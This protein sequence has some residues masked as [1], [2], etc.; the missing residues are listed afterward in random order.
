MSTQNPDANRQTNIIKYQQI[1]AAAQ[2]CCSQ[3]RAEPVMN[4]RTDISDNSP[5]CNSLRWEAKEER[6][7]R[8]RPGRRPGAVRRAPT[9]PPRAEPHA[10]CQCH[11]RPPFINDDHAELLRETSKGSFSSVSRAS[12][13]SKLTHFVGF[14]GVYKYCNFCTSLFASF[15]FFSYESLRPYIRTTHRFYK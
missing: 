6:W 1:C 5:G 4:I 8:V 2:I 11:V 3:N 15:L 14:F 12:L 10:P 13:G 7:K 9:A